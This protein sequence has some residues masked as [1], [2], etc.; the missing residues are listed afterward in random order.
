MSTEAKKLAKIAI[1][2]LIALSMTTPA[3][4]QAASSSDDYIKCYGVA[5]SNKNDCGTS[6]SACAASIKEAGACYAWIYAPEAIC[7]KLA[8]ASVGTQAKDC[9]SPKP[10][11]K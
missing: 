4:T 6:L 11:T 3:V 7:K 5:A 1:A 10:P 9:V 2:S 8:N